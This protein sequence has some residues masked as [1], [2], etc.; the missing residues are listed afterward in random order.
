MGKISFMPWSKVWL[1]LCWFSPNSPL[2]DN[3]L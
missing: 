2:Q 1:L 3:F